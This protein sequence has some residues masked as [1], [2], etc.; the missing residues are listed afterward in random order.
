MNSIMNMLGVAS[1][2]VPKFNQEQIDMVKSMVKGQ[3]ISAEAWVRQICAQRGID[4]DEFM[5]Q[6]KDVSL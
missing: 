2:Q 6:F 3:G 1:K 5:E 4:V